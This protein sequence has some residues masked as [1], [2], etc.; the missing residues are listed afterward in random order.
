MKSL[1]KSLARPFRLPTEWHYNSPPGIRLADVR[2]LPEL[3]RRAQAWDELLL[4]SGRSAPVLSYAWIYAY[5]KH[6][7]RPR[8]SWLCLFAY[9]GSRLVGVM[10]L[11]TGKCYS[12]GVI[13]LTPFQL[14]S[15]IFHTSGADCLTR[16][17]RED[18]LEIF[19]DYLNHIPR[20]V[21][22]VLFR[23]V[24]VES[25]PM[26]LARASDALYVSSHFVSN[27]NAVPLPKTRAEYSA[28]MSSNL[29]RYLKKNARKLEELPGVRFRVPEQE[30]PPRE[31]LTEFVDV[32]NRN[33]KGRELSSVKARP[34]DLG[35][36]TDIAE[37]MTRRGWM[38]WNF[39]EAD[40]KTIAGQ[41]AVRVNRVLNLVKIGFDD[42]Y[43]FCSPGNLL[44]DK[45]IS[46]AIESGDVDEVNMMT[47]LDWHKKWQTIP[48]P[49]YNA[50]VYPR[51]PLISALARLGLLKSVHRGLR[52]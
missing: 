9:E 32:E 25:S 33:W 36:L 16:P 41:Y 52:I 10:P 18:V 15:S 45:V 43:G 23:L 20:T 22:V 29:R 42:D 31:C 24:P 48:R 3:A 7:L 39:L 27:E 46:R 4:Q 47:D 37:A 28:R 21:P 49:L 11:V 13:R 50:V 12:I 26:R 2:T 51:S 6:Q 1:A 19:V 8:E 5:L 40:C 44:M 30:R 17:G 14:P 35:M 34:A 38:V